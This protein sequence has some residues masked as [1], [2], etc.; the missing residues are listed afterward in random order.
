LP[1]IVLINFYF[2][3]SKTP[4]DGVCP[5]PTFGATMETNQRAFGS[6]DTHFVADPFGALYCRAEIFLPPYDTT[7]TLAVLPAF[8]TFAGGL[9]A[10]RGV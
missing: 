6:S 7:A 9:H 3:I 2:E 4:L 8:G 5:N 1:L 10:R